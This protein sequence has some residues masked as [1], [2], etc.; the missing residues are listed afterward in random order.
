M[1]FH[2]VKDPFLIFQR[3]CL[4][5]AYRSGWRIFHWIPNYLSFLSVYRKF[6]N[7]RRANIRD[8]AFFN[9]VDQASIALGPFVDKELVKHYV[10]GFSPEIHVAET[11]AVLRSEEE[12][13]E[14]TEVRAYVAKP[15]HTYGVAVFRPEGGKLDHEEVSKLS[16]SLEE[17]LYLDGGEIQYRHPEP[18]IIVEEFIGDPPAVPSDFKAHCHRGRF[19]TCSFVQGRHT[20]DPR[21]A[22]FD[23]G[24][25][26]VKASVKSPWVDTGGRRVGQ[27]F[28]L[29]A[30]YP[31]LIEAAEKLSAPFEY[32]RVDLY[33]VGD[34]VYFGE[35]TFSPGNCLFAMVPKE[36]EDVETWP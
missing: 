1:S 21:R 32:V 6:P 12:L 29:P 17:N 28:E 15:T 31:R 23:R 19:L 9:K 26:R 3:I 2:P 35:L 7:R 25:N 8:M 16:R 33:L 5:L 20:D 10:K 27:D 22:R 24:G 11:Y 34:D 30:A 14:L 13:R 18:K 36:L 4:R